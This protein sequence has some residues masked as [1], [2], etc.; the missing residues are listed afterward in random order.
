MPWGKLIEDEKTGVFW[1]I[2]EDEA[3]EQYVLYSFDPETN[4]AKPHIDLGETPFYPSSLVAAPDG[5]IWMVDRED[6]GLLYYDP[7]EEEL[8]TFQEIIRSTYREMPRV[9]MNISPEP[10][11]QLYVDR[12]NRLWVGDIGW[13]D[14]SDPSNLVWYKVIRSPVFL[15]EN[16]LPTSYYTWVRPDFIYQATNGIYWFSSVAG[17]VRL[18]PATAEWSLITTFSSAVAEDDDQNIWIVIDKKIFKFDEPH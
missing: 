14:F 15:A 2:L 11:T 16:Y 13:L 10:G 4:I 1:M 6:K 18:D 17:I 9:T 5:N 3:R 7:V 8:H 12:Y